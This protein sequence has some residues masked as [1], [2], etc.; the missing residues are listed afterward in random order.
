MQLGNLDSSG[1][2]AC[3]SALPADVSA[4][5]NHSSALQAGSP[6]FHAD[7]FALDTHE[8]PPQQVAASSEHHPRTLLSSPITNADLVQ[9]LLHS[10]AWSCLAA[11]ADFPD[12]LPELP[13]D[14]DALIGRKLPQILDHHHHGPVRLLS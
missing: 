7:S 14:A 9:Q 4:L 12:D 11:A 5:P 1:S 6:A 10:Y 13:A 2:P 3:T 8:Q